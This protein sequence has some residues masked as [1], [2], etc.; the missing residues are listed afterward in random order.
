MQSPNL[1]MDE[2]YDSLLLFWELTVEKQDARCYLSAQV[3]ESSSCESKSKCIIQNMSLVMNV[4]VTLLHMG[5]LKDTQHYWLLFWVT[6]FIT[7]SCLPF[8]M[9]LPS[10]YSLKKSK[11]ELT[12]MYMM[13]GGRSC[14]KYNT[15]D[16]ALLEVK[17]EKVVKADIFIWWTTKGLI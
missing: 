2:V 9:P 15:Q 1:N 5:G 7:S 16:I 3:S 13:G 6:A 8:F 11:I 4:Q 12:S 10:V 14:T 17:L